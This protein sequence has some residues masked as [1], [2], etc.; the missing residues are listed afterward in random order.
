VRL[1]ITRSKT[2]YLVP[3][4]KG[5]P[6]F[7]ASR[8]KKFRQNLRRGLQRCQQLGET[9]FVR[10][11]G[12][13]MTLS[14]MIDA[15]LQVIDRSWKAPTDDQAR[16]HRFFRDLMTELAV[17]GLLSWRCLELNGQPIASLVELDYRQNLHPFH[18]A[19]D[20]GYQPLSPGIVILGDAV[21]DVHDRRYGRLDT[22][23][24]ADYLH[25]WADSTRSFDQLRIVNTSCF[26]R[27]KA[28]LYQWERQRRLGRA[29]RDA[30]TRKRVKL[31][32]HRADKDACE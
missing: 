8:P 29:E 21:R 20:L 13:D 25:R 7:L 15:T 1:A 12:D 23:G 2:T 17:G 30:E 5:W 32:A 24:S 4:R 18:L 31:K 26:S 28:R 9:R 19:V 22:G 14:Q 27:V 16:W 3:V 11:P 6:E 10:Y